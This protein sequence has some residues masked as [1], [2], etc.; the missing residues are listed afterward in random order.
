ME[1]QRPCL[2]NPDAILTYRRKNQAGGAQ[3]PVWPK[4]RLAQSGIFRSRN[5]NPTRAARFPSHNAWDE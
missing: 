1:K 4:N 5:I 2:S 3:N